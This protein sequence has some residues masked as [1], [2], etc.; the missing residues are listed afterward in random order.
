MYFHTGRYTSLSWVHQSSLLFSICFWPKSPC[1][2]QKWIDIEPNNYINKPKFLLAL[3]LGVFCF[4]WVRFIT[5]IIMCII[6][7]FSTIWW[8]P[9]TQGQIWF[10]PH[11]VYSK[12]RF[13]VHICWLTDINWK[14]NWLTVIHPHDNPQICGLCA[15]PSLQE[16]LIPPSSGW[17]SENEIW[18]LNPKD[19]WGQTAHVGKES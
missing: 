6:F 10:T 2:V 17:L 5:A 11:N 3:D 12:W 8:A 15:L 19:R 18:P 13:S 14:N 7:T 1:P 9:R 16:S 4:S